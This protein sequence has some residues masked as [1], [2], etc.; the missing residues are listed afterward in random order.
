MDPPST[1]LIE[2]LESLHLASASEVAACRQAVRK[3]SRGLPTFDSVWVD[4]LVKRQI[5]TPFQAKF[6]DEHRS[7]ELKVNDNLVLTEQIHFD[8]VMPMFRAIDPK[9]NESVI[10]SKVTLDHSDR[11]LPLKRVEQLFA[12]LRKLEDSGTSPT[13]FVFRLADHSLFLISPDC[14]GISLT[15]LLVRRGRMP[16]DVVCC[17]AVEI[18]RQ[19]NTFPD[20]LTHH[21]LRLANVW[22]DRLGTVAIFNHGMLHSVMP[23]LSIHQTLPR[24]FYDTIAPERTTGRM[25]SGER[26]DLYSLGCMMWQLLAGRPPFIIADPL[27]KLDAHRNKRMPPIQEFAPETTQA[28][29]DLIK[30]LTDQNP[31]QR[32][33]SFGVVIELLSS[34]EKISRSRLQQFAR[35][36][37]S[38]APRQVEKPSSRAS[39][40]VLRATL[41]MVVIAASLF[42]LMNRDQFSLSVAQVDSNETRG[43]VESQPEESAQEEILLVAHHVA[44]QDTASQDGQSHLLIPNSAGVI[45]LNSKEPIRLISI[46]HS[47]SLVI[48]G[49]ASER[50]VLLVETDSPILQA[51]QVVFENV[52]LRFVSVG[53]LEIDASRLRFSQCVVRGRESSLSD[54]LIHWKSDRSS[55][56]L[57]LVVSDSAFQSKDSVL[58]LTSP[59]TAARVENLY[60]DCEAATFEL[61]AGVASGFR[62]PAIFDQSTFCGGG[63]IAR[64]TMKNSQGQ[65]GVL[66]IQGRETVVVTSSSD[67]VIEIETKSGS[68][69]SQLAEFSTA[70]MIVQPETILVGTRIDL[71]DQIEALPTDDLVVNGV[72]TGEFHFEESEHGQECIP[73]L[74]VLVVDHLPVRNSIDLPGFD[75][76]RFC[77]PRSGL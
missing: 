31:E 1:Q 16:E 46:E 7:H 12:Q 20:D 39:G 38:A 57:G 67:A 50:T 43:T 27:A 47:N 70:G 52:E 74:K 56:P 66:S 17:I 9:T 55:A 32:P 3:L 49:M 35:S 77:N 18:A 37:E 73:G 65:S 40:I 6:F 53:S 72:L 2:V 62:V 63:P 42:V 48:K 34:R 11:D 76:K 44:E 26:A 30:I 41:S 10:V 51:P 29:A 19:L 59:L 22:L 25:N 60:A 24:D 14:S 64:L 71:S 58:K 15:Q 75:S 61:A 28:T 54:P 45:E 13:E 68:Q 8:A 69:N 5:L 33:A 23:E 36:F 4:V 21:D